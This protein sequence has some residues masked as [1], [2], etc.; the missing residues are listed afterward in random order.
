MLYRR[1]ALLFFEVIH[2]IWRSHGP[3]NRW[4]ESNF[5]QIT[6][7]VAVIKSLRF[8]LF[9]IICQ[10]SRSHGTKKSPI[11]TRI[12]RFQTVTP[13]WIHWYGYEIMH[14]A[15]SIMTD[16]PYCFSRSSVKFQDH[17]GQ[18]IK[19]L[20]LSSLALSLLLLLSLSWF[21]FYLSMAQCVNLS[22]T[23][24]RHYSL[25]FPYLRQLPALLHSKH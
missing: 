22:V 10:I 15:W 2:Q 13:V 23:M 25:T 8:D 19:L 20:L 4:F 24:Y 12:E 18:I 21:F 6:R 1:V 16:V 5:K 9:R 11:L 7:L 3:K 17:T 14:K